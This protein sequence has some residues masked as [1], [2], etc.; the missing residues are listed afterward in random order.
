M[1]NDNKP[2]ASANMPPK[3]SMGEI[4]EKMADAKVTRSQLSPHD[5]KILDSATKQ[6][7]KPSDKKTR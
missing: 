1:N 5:K 4:M 6:A 2:Q 3:M 7:E